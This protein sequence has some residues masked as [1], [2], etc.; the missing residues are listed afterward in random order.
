[1]NEFRTVL[2][3]D[4]NANDVELTLLAFKES[5][6]ANRIEVVKD[7]VEVMEFLNYEGKF[8]MRKKELPAVILLDVKMPRMDGIEVLEKIRTNPNFRIIPVVMLSSSREESDLKK[9][10]GLGVN[11]YVVK[12]VDIK[13]F[14]EAI[15]HVGVF[16]ALINELPPMDFTLSL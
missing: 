4:D 1:M 9:C 3:A 15:S 2:L 5:G 13:K 14:I 6:L 16:W 11:G 10:Y 8:S 7:G 12:P